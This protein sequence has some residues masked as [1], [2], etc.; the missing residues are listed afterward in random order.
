[1]FGDRVGGAADGVEVAVVFEVAMDQPPAQSSCLAIMRM[2]V[3]A[4][5]TQDASRGV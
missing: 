2:V 1:M 5:F 4:F 3:I